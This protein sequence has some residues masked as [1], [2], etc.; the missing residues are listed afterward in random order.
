MG[1]EYF[2]I[3]LTTPI[4][5]EKEETKISIVCHGMSSPD[6]GTHFEPGLQNSMPR[7]TP[8]EEDIKLLSSFFP[9]R[10]FIVYVYDEEDDHYGYEAI[11]GEIFR[12]LKCD[13]IPEYETL[14]EH[15]EKRN[16]VNMQ[17]YFD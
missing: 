14:E 17:P 7:H 9:D 13:A 16:L 5:D 2:Y 8:D 3:V 4:I 10:L 12:H 11:G 1:R 15:V 6:A